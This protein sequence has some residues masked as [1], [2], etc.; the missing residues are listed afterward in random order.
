MYR[1]VL[2]IRAW[3]RWR[4]MAPKASGSRR[5]AW[6]AQDRRSEWPEAVDGKPTRTARS[7]TALRIF[8][9]GM[10]ASDLEEWWRFTKSGPS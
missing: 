6:V 10:F 5:Y 7:R 2:E 8:S 4:E 3:R 1:T 9:A